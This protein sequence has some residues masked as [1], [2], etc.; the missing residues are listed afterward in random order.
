MKH[1]LYDFFFG[2]LIIIRLDVTSLVFILGYMEPLDFQVV[3]VFSNLLSVAIIKY[4]KQKQ[5]S[6][7]KNLFHLMLPGPNPSLKEVR[8]ENWEK[9]SSL[10][11]FSLA[12]SVFFLP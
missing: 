8:S 4:T 1:S 6:K 10:D 11:L 9:C 12:C 2:E 5:I 7:G 3:E